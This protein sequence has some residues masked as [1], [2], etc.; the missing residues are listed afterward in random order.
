MSIVVQFGRREVGTS[1]LKPLRARAS[2]AAGAPASQSGVLFRAERPSAQMLAQPTRPGE[3][4]RSW[5]P[6]GEN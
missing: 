1:L 2:W 5:L 4:L 3:F 6:L